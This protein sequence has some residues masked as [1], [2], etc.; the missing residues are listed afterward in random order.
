MET[1]ECSAC[2]KC[3]V[4]M[5][6]VIA[7]LPQLVSIIGEENAYFP[8]SHNNGICEKLVLENNLCSVYKDRP[9]ICNMEKLTEA[10]AQKTGQDLSLVKQ[11]MYIEGK[12]ICKNLQTE[13]YK[14]VT[15]Q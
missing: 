6:E 4:R 9:V 2:G 5:I 12:K 1:F 10:I 13:N 15:T 11:S 7:G 8:Y 3:C 14:F